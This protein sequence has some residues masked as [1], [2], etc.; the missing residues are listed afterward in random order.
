M[1]AFVGSRCMGL[2]RRA[3]LRDGGVLTLAVFVAACVVVPRTA[4]VS[5][6]H[7]ECWDDEYHLS[8]GLSLLEAASTGHQLSP[9]HVEAA[10]AL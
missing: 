7:S 2:T 5:R 4:L 10:I 3:L 6:A 1:G 9:Y 8:L